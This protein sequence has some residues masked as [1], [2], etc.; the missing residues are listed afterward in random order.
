MSLD[1]RR[2]LEQLDKKQLHQLARS[3]NIN[4]PK[5]WSRTPIV[6]LLALNVSKKD[7]QTINQLPLK[8]RTRPKDGSAIIIK[9]L[10]VQF[11]DVTAVDGLNL[12]IREGELFSLLGPNGAGKTTTINIL[13]G[14]LKPTK[15]TAVVGGYDVKI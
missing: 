10:V 14:I 8:V 2:S 15:G 7:L 6:E 13:S 1:I 4:I 12:E 3:K 5:E 9:D 11:E